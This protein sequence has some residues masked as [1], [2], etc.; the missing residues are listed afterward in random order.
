MLGFFNQVLMKTFLKRFQ[1]CYISNHQSPG[2]FKV[3]WRV[4]NFSGIF[5]SNS[6][7]VNVTLCA[8]K[9]DQRVHVV[10]WHI[11]LRC[12]INLSNVTSLRSGSRHSLARISAPFSDGIFR[13]S[14]LLDVNGGLDTRAWLGPFLLKP[15]KLVFSLSKLGGLHPTEG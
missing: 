15:W 4:W 6:T 7:Q 3:S 10:Q 2:I 12:N 14:A 5:H 9:A 13:F 8:K 1:M 11:R